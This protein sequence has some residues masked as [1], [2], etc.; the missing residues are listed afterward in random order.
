MKTDLTRFEKGTIGL[1]CLNEKK[2]ALSKFGIMLNDM[3]KEVFDNMTATC[4]CCGSPLILDILNINFKNNNPEGY[5]PT[6]KWFSYF[7]LCINAACSYQYVGFLKKEFW[8]ENQINI[9]KIS[10]TMTFG[11]SPGTLSLPINDTYILQDILIL[12]K[13]AGYKKIKFGARNVF[14]QAKRFSEFP[15]ENEQY[16]LDPKKYAKHCYS[17]LDALS[18]NMM[19]I[20]AYK[21]RGKPCEYNNIDILSY[22]FYNILKIGKITSLDVTNKN[23]KNLDSYY[24]PRNVIEK[25]ILKV[26]DFSIRNRSSLLQYSKSA[27]SLCPN[28]LND[29]SGLIDADRIIY[30]KNHNNINIK[31]FG[32]IK[33]F[34]EKQIPDKEK[35]SLENTVKGEDYPGSYDVYCAERYISDKNSYEIPYVFLILAGLDVDLLKQ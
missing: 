18:S 12:L 31:N 16:H 2:N 17:L 6:T 35:L 23:Q 21:D 28:Q 27:I 20:I 22:I 19:T 30:D 10:H 5:M 29:L 34:V 3:F 11:L 1:A 4:P 24:L 9:N 25:S 15:N 32:I 33:Q 7:A 13:E 14:N 26:L 8:P